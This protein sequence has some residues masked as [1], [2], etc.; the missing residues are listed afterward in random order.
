MVDAEIIAAMCDSMREIGL[1]NSEAGLEY[2]IEINNRKLVD[3]LL[4][5]CGIL[6]DATVKAGAFFPLT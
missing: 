3:A 6:D 2:Q 1:R 5:D 4:E